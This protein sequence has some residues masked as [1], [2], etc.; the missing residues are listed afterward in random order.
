ML[1]LIHILL[2]DEGRLSVV[3]PTDSHHSLESAN[4]D[5]NVVVT[6]SDHVVMDVPEF[7]RVVGNCLKFTAETDSI[8]TLGMKAT[9][10]ETCLLYTSSACMANVADT[11]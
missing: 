7:K 3:I 11:V 9:R 5:A 2:S 4:P 6:P 8:V 10:P 1:S